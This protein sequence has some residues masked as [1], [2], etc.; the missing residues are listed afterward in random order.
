M[1]HEVTL[2]EKLKHDIE[3]LPLEEIFERIQSG[4]YG[5]LTNPL[6]RMLKEGNL[7]GYSFAKLSLP[8]VT[9]CALFDGRRVLPNMV[10][11][12]NMIVLDIDHLEEDVLI[13]AKRIICLCDYT[14][15][16]YIS[17]SGKG[18][19]VFVCVSTGSEE[20]KNAFIA[21]QQ[22]YMALTGLNIDPSGKDI[23]RLCFVSYDRELYYNPGATV[24]V[25]LK[26]SIQTWPPAEPDK[27]V[28]SG[29]NTNETNI[30]NDNNVG[31]ALVAAHGNDDENKNVVGVPVTERSRSD[32]NV[33]SNVVSTPLNDQECDQSNN[34][35][36]WALHQPVSGKSPKSIIETIQRCKD[37]VERHCSYVVGQR[38]T[39]VFALAIQFRSRGFDE[40]FTLME[41][42]QD[43]NFDEREVRNCV[44]YAYSYVWVN[45][46]LI[47]NGNENKIYI[48]HGRPQ[49]RP[50]HFQQS[51]EA[52]TNLQ[53]PEQQNPSAFESNESNNF[54]A[55]GNEENVGAAL[56]AAQCINTDKDGNVVAAHGDAIGN[57]EN[58]N[59]PPPAPKPSSKKYS[60]R[61]TRDLFS[62]WYET[63]FNK[64]T[65]VI[66]WR[67]AHT[68][69]PFQRLEDHQ[70]NSMLCRL[71]NAGQPIPIQMFHILINSDFSPVYNPFISYKESLKEPDGTTDYIKQ[72]SDTV[73]TEN[74]LH[75]AFCFKKWF[76]GYAVALVEDDIVNQTVIVLVGKQGGGK[77]TWMKRLVPPT[78]SNY[79]GTAALQTDSKDTAIQLSECCLI[80]LDEMENL[81]RKDISSFKEMITRPRMR[82]RRPYGRNY[83][84]LMHRAS[85]IAAVNSK[86]IL[87]DPTGSRRFL[88]HEVK[89][90]DYFHKVDIDAAFAQAYALYKEGFQYWFDQDEIEE[91]TK[92][93]DDF[94]SKSVEEELIEIW[95][96]PVTREE[97]D[98]RHKYANALNY[99][100]MNATQ[101]A[102]KLMEK[103]K[104]LLGD[105]TIVKIGKVMHKLN[106]EQVRKGNISLYLVRVVDAEVVDKESHVLDDNP[107]SP[108]ELYANT[109]QRE[110]QQ[111]IMLEEDLSDSFPKDDLPF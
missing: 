23:T 31:A 88:C 2:Y 50:L 11:Y 73:K 80:I 26:G 6:R 56:V 81:N 3:H 32:Q 36:S 33:I 46:P 109:E 76:V 17:P 102:I 103:A 106:Y 55:I 83:D 65:G 87:T 24:F 101:V 28:L 64:V 8:A 105:N 1:K 107:S 90:I 61:K 10:R 35:P 42:L 5:Y 41:L 77:T 48:A 37:Y 15:G 7:Q 104:M 29:E 25:P 94:M 30:E 69:E 18:L 92:H 98:N 58:V 47:E 9:P 19:K 97:W 95:L 72:L 93:N 62:Q 60:L 44:K 54:N 82:I 74:D 66:E 49:G 13:E 108:T 110:D 71:H 51:P 63:H 86:Q 57:E 34:I 111:I 16:C 89:E 100:L 96:R 79:L 68:R 40:S 14:Y 52:N 21:V 22:F 20:H 12:N 70:E 85:F 38:H 4:H 59:P 99:H 84:N 27:P 43:Y 39:Y 53:S 75:F 67:H 78:L 45:D 91:L